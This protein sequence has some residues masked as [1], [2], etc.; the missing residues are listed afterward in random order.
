DTGFGI[1]PS[2][3]TPDELL[4]AFVW[5]KPGGEG[6]GTSD[7]S[8]TRYDEMCNSDSSLVPG[9]LLPNFLHPLLHAN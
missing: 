1:R 5:V 6:D 8:A 4:D 2:S 3:D 9:E 7:E